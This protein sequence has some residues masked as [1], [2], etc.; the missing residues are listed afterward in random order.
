MR[1]RVILHNSASLDGRVDFGVGFDLGVHYEAF[2]ALGG[3][4]HLV[5]SG[6]ILA[7]PAAEQEGAPE[8]GPDDPPPPVESGRTDGGGLLVVADGRG[9]V[10]RWTSLRGA[11]L[12]TRFAA[13][14][15]RGTPAE[16]LAHLARR[17]VEAIVAGNARVDLAA[18]LELL[19]GR[20]GVRTVGADAGPTL[21]GALL[22]AGLVDEVSL[23]VHPSIAGAEAPGAVLYAP[24]LGGANAVRLRLTHLERLRD[25]VVHLRYATA[26]DPMMGT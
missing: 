25:N 14:V 10:R 4:A 13:L 1:P 7:M 6:T 15:H 2:G 22:S 17:G 11:G 5:G 20:L 3:E 19:A 26:S 12:W 16:Y 18:A 21:N 8:D 9:R 23:L 24:P